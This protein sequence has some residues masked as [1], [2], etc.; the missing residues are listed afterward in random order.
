MARDSIP[1]LALLYGPKGGTL[2]KFRHATAV[3]ALDFFL[4][5]AALGTPAIT[6]TGGMAT[7]MFANNRTF[8][9]DFRTGG[10]PFTIN[11]LGVWD[12]DGNGLFEAH[13]VG[14]WDSTGTSLLV[15]ATVPAGTVANLDSQFRFVPV[16]PT[17]LPANTQFVV[18]EFFGSN[19]DAIIRHTVATTVSAITLG[20]TRFDRFPFVGD[21]APPTLEQGTT[22]DHGYFGPNFNG[23]VP[24]PSASLLA[25][26]AVTLLSIRRRKSVPHN[27]V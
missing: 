24:E 10:S 22:Y 15:S 9:F 19:S 8:G 20:S 18:G 7:T 17:V 5:S 12:Q 3:I 25:F 2:M 4:A 1:Q 21:F 13:Q 14:I 11:S 23:V 27:R 6:L 26:V 16:S